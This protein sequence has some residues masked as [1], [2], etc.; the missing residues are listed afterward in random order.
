MKDSAGLDDDEEIIATLQW[1]AGALLRTAL[2][3]YE[4]SP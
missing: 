1:A 4:T 3:D 2:H